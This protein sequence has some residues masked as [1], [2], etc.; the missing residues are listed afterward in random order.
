MDFSIP[1]ITSGRG[2]SVLVPHSNPREDFKTVYRFIELEQRR[3]SAGVTGDKSKFD[4][5]SLR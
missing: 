1:R 3:L 5:R 4:D 2:T